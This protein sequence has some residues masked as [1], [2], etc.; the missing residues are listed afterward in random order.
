VTE[1]MWTEH[2]DRMYAGTSEA[3][4]RRELVSLEEQLSDPGLGLGNRYRRELEVKLACVEVALGDREYV[5]SGADCAICGGTGSIGGGFV[6]RCLSV[7]VYTTPDEDAYL[8]YQAEQG[9]YY[10][11][12]QVD[13]LERQQCQPAW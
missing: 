9:D 2:Y 10:V 3:E 13:A 12:A 7:A 8:A 5:A 1:R 11:L 4:L 6:C